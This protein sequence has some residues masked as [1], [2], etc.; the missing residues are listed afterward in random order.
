MFGQSCWA[1]SALASVSL[2]PRARTAGSLASTC[3]AK[4]GSEI[5]TTP[6]NA[7]KAAAAPRIFGGWGFVTRSSRK[8]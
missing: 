2:S 5:N 4:V 6:A 1:Q 7:A 8:A 3:G